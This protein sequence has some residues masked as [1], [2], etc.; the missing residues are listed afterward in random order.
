MESPVESIVDKT[1]FFD[2]ECG[3]DGSVYAIGAIF[4]THAPLRGRN[5]EQVRREMPA[6]RD[7]VGAADYICGHNIISHDLPKLGQ[8]RGP[9]NFADKVVDT[10]YLSPI[11]YPKS[12][13][14]HLLKE[15]KLA[16]ESRN[17]PVQDSRS[18][19]QL[20]GAICEKYLKLKN[21]DL[22]LYAYAFHLANLPG[23]AALFWRLL[24]AK[25]GQV[26]PLTDIRNQHL[27]DLFRQQ[28]D[29]RCCMESLEVIE[30]GNGPLVLAYIHAWLQSAAGTSSIPYWVCNHIPQI[31]SSLRKLRVEPCASPGCA[32]C[33]KTHDPTNALREHFGFPG[34]REKPEVKGQ[35]GQS[36]QEAIVAAAM[37]EQ[38]VL[39]ILPTGG[40]K[41]LCFQVPALHRYQ[42]TGALSV[43]ISPLQSLMRDQV[44]NLKNRGGIQ[45]TAALYGLLTPAERRECLKDIRLGHIGLLYVSPEQLRSPPFKK[46]IQQREIAYWIFDEAHCLSKWG[47]DFRV[48]YLYA[49]KFIGAL[50]KKASV[51]APTVICV[52]ATAKE[53]VKNELIDH[54]QKSIRQN[55]ELLD[56]GTDRSNL[57]YRVEIVKRSDKPKR[58]K[59]LLEGFYGDLPADPDLEM[60]RRFTD[61]CLEKGA[62]VIFAA[63]V[64]H[65]MDIYEWLA[66]EGWPVLPYHG[67]LKDEEAAEDTGQEKQLT[68]K[69]VLDQFLKHRAIPIV[70]ATNAFGMGVDKADIRIVI[71]AD[72]TGSLENYLQEAGRAGRDGEPAECI[73][74]YES[75]DLET[76]FSMCYMSQLT[77]RNMQQIW[78]AV[79]ST[80]PDA[81]ETITISA[82]EIIEKVGSKSGFL[83]DDADLDDTKVKTGI[84]ILED[85][86]FLE[87]TDNQARVFEARLLVNSLDEAR[88]KIDRVRVPDDVRR[89]WVAVVRCFLNEHPDEKL[90]V[91]H[92]AELDEMCLM[93]ERLNAH[94]ERVRSLTALVFRTLNSMAKPE[95]GLIQ[96]ELRF[97]AAVKPKAAFGMMDQLEAHESALIR[98][99][100]EAFPEACGHLRV[101]LRRYNEILTRHGVSSSVE[102]ITRAFHAISRD[103]ERIGDGRSLLT[104]IQKHG[105]LNLYIEQGFD[106]IKQHSTLRLELCREV[107]KHIISL[108]PSKADGAYEFNEAGL[109]KCLQEN[110]KF[111]GEFIEYEEVLQYLLVWLHD[112]KVVELKQGRALITSAMSIKLN[113]NGRVNGRKRRLKHG[114]FEAQKN[115]Y[116]GRRVQVHVVGEYAKQAA[117]SG[118]D[119]HLRFIQDYFSMQQAAFVKKYF[120]TKEQKKVLELATGIESY[121]RIVESL[122]QNQEQQ[123]IVQSRDGANDMVLAGP[124]SGK[125]TVIAHRC[126]YLLRMRRVKRSSIVVL[127]FNRHA[128][129]Q[130]RRKVYELVGDD[131]AGVVI[132][133][134]HG[135]ALRLLGRTMAQ[136][137]SEE[138]SK[139]L[140]FDEI[141]PA[142]IKLLES[143]AET[144]SIDTELWRRQLIGNL[145]HILVDE[146]QD[147]DEI[148]Y[149]F[150]SLLSGKS[151][152]EG[153]DKL[154][155]L[156][157]GDDDQSIYGFAGASVKYIRQFE[158]DYQ[159]RTNPKWIK[160]VQMHHMV[161]NYRSTRNIIAAANA[162]IANNLDRMKMAHP[163]K[164]DSLRSQQEAAGGFMEELDPI[165]GGKIQVLEIHSRLE[166][167]YACV[168]EIQRYLS[169]SR[170]HRPVHCCVIARTNADLMPVRVALEQAKIPCSIVGSDS[171]PNLARVR[172]IYGWLEYL[173]TKKGQLWSG[174]KL[175]GKLRGRLGVSF[176]RT[177]FGRI[178]DR[179]GSEFQ[180][181][182]GDAEILCEDILDYFYDA[183]FEQKR[184]GFAST[185]VILSTAHKV[186]GLEFDNIIILDGNWV[187][188][189]KGLAQL[190]EARRLY[191]VAFTRAKK[192]ITLFEHPE[193]PNRFIHEIPEHLVYRRSVEVDI[194]DP[195]L[196]ELSYNIINLDEL[197]IGF[198]AYLKPMDSSSRALQRAGPGDPVSLK[199]ETD[200]NGAEH[201]Y[202]FNRYGKKLGQLSKKGTA[203][204]KPRLGCVLNA[205]L[206]SVH[207]RLREDGNGNNKGAQA[208]WYIPIVEVLWSKSALDT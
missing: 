144:E 187:D 105:Y 126:A 148:A 45:H 176:L 120:R 61:S 113:E 18:C 153:Q 182:V 88:E 107:L 81:E 87:R 72:A 42:A 79:Y 28:N 17:D 115:H 84:N 183:L 117:Y 71:H 207:T 141:I 196:L 108:E 63:T 199:L 22:A 97:S 77:L 171:V 44:E 112:N 139:G 157:V 1:V 143:K 166:Q 170:L 201:V 190:E 91:R 53:D 146:Y 57:D 129:L 202:V 132:Q 70:V 23:M 154:R 194:A 104:C 206:T 78:D 76:Q 160:P 165:T 50:A 134:Y 86:G 49:S 9:E 188:Q 21:E 58:V 89:L 150:V 186:K 16:K 95:V 34:Y 41:S 60:Y 24:Q 161:Q 192:C 121:R 178:I 119:S 189:H 20:L 133:T 19:Q 184:R 152:L 4:R 116:E 142:A 137:D 136:I 135:L 14:H 111:A 31:R 174:N 39:G 122:N 3:E 68:K 10:L 11:A 149:K 26:P 56:G 208:K 67:R 172:E 40:G 175:Y 164:I 37:H 55:L 180:V 181:E 85:R 156:A 48:D 35:P 96:K 69:Y 12:N 30:G 191:Y 125:T 25:G 140:S 185:G 128:A 106:R 123:A 51:E 98:E 204:W 102:M 147:I 2:L 83:A 7:W 8:I 118:G 100:E 36:L 145:T 179:I 66:Q 6:L 198:S 82:D 193:Y 32:Y 73:L 205:K 64:K 103:G 13:Y 159:D 124:G 109:V 163:I 27:S 173:K 59:D 99:A 46:S 43:V 167:P 90:E 5:S 92:L 200:K 47:H 74:L 127:C 62:V 29:D 52:T 151:A 93:F 131:A 130:L 65:V 195:K 162:I 75:E 33:R 203:N 168:G 197:H 80:K 101:S 15:D 54:F 138:Q 169:L 155:I 114:D 110:T 38:P 94:G 177:T 158:Q